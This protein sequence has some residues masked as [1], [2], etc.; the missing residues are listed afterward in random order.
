VSRKEMKKQFID[1][2]DFV[3]TGIKPVTAAALIRFASGRLDKRL[4]C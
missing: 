3:T 2:L 1:Y 4:A